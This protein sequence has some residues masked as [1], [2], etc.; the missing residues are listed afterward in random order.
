MTFSA[1]PGQTLRVHVEVVSDVECESDAL[2]END[3]L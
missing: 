2:H 3:A 1:P